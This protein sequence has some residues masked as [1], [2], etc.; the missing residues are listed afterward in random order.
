MSHPRVVVEG[1]RLQLE[2]MQ[3]PGGT[4]APAVEVLQQQRHQ[5]CRSLFRAIA[6]PGSRLN[7]Y[8]VA[9]PK[10]AIQRLIWTRLL[11]P[12]LFLTMFSDKL[13]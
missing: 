7:P 11:L 10:R 3:H 5:T 8:A 9:D 4:A 6:C 2:E 1:A 12:R 13:T